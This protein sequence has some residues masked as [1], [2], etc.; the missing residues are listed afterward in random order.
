MK[1]LGCKCITLQ[2]EASM[3]R[4]CPAKDLAKIYYK[5]TAKSACNK[6][7]KIRR[8]WTLRGFNGK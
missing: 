2:T 3:S 6:F 8:R 4:E 5:F 7:V 1:K